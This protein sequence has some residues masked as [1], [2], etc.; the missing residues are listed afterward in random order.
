MA[1]DSTHATTRRRALA[2]LGAGAGL[3]LAGC[4]GGSSSSGGKTV[5]YLSDRGDSKNIMDKIVNEFEKNSKYTVDVTYTAHGNSTDEQLQKMKAAGHPPDIIFVTSADA[6]RYQKNGNAA[7]VT[8]AVKD[9]N[10]P[11]PVH[12]NG[13]SYF[14]PAVVEPLMGWYRNDVYDSDP[15]TWSKWQAEAKRVTQ[16][17]GMDGYVVQSGQTNN[18][19][20]SITQYLWN[21]G[22]NIYSGKPGN[23]TVEVDKGDNK[24]KAIDTFT[25]VKEMSQ[26]SPNGSGWEWGDAIGALQQ[27][28]AAAIPSV[29]GLA[30]LSIKANRPKLVD[31]LSPMALPVPSGRSMDPWWA[32]MEGMVVRSDGD[33]TDGARQ[34]VDFFTKSSSFMDFVLSQ[35]LFQFPPRKSQLNSDAVKNNDTLQN[36]TDVLDLVKNNWDHFSTILETGT[37]GAPNITAANAYNVQA[38]GQAAD[39]MVVGG[40]SP[41][42]TVDWLGKKLRSL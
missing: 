34:F 18:A 16:N 9:N 13:D 31:K 15:K 3:A 26:Y 21:N 29:G 7:T 2:T 10:L 24:Q 5:R 23:I 32:Y 40:K 36:H 17:T 1:H 20:T 12:V 19:D 37:D 30:I 11:D 35:P 25:W 33:A 39:Q 6:Y 8:Q 14:A 38:F 4:T 27:E 42:E 28:N 22:V 41:S